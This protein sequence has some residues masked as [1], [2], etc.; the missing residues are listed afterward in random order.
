MPAA[1]AAR[2]TADRLVDLDVEVIVHP[3]TYGV[4]G[5]Q[6][7]A[8][9]VL[10]HPSGWVLVARPRLVAPDA[11]FP[12]WLIPVEVAAKS[13]GDALALARRVDRIL[14][15]TPRSPTAFES[16]GDEDAGQFGNGFK[17]RL[18]YVATLRHEE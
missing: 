7:W 14:R 6:D 18:S 11:L 4:D 1:D 12:R 16:Q 5:V 8:W 3:R 17:I 10:N 13:H 15:G 9:F 2:V